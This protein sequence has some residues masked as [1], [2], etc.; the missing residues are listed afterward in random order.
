[1]YENCFDEHEE[2]Q[3]TETKERE[4]GGYWRIF[5][6][7][8]IDFYQS[9]ILP[10]KALVNITQTD[11]LSPRT[12]CPHGCFVPTDVLSDGRFVPT[13]VLSDGRF[14]A[15]DILSPRM[16]CPH[17]R[18]VHGHFVSGHFVWAPS[19]LVS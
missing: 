4:C 7:R 18:F 6:S 14:V 11:V 3:K 17:G 1:M 5:P 19:R 12:F 13:D 16:F 8:S 9:K 2:P 15:M 10:N